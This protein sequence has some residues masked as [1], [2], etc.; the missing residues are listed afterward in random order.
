MK[1]PFVII[2][3]VLLFQTLALKA[4]VADNDGN[5]ALINDYASISKWDRNTSEW[6]PS[7]QQV[8][9]YDEGMNLVQIVSLNPVTSDTLSRVIYVYDDKGSMTAE[10][11]QDYTAGMWVDKLRYIMGYDENDMRMSLTIYVRSNGEWV[12]SSRQVNYRYDERNLLVAYDNELWYETGWRLS[13]VDNFT[14]D[15][16]GIL[17]FRIRTDMT[18]ANAFRIYYYYNAYQ[19][20]TQMFVQSYQR[21]TGLWLN[22]YRDTYFY[23]SCGTRISNLRERFVNGS[24]I[25]E[26]KADLFY[27][28]TVFTSDNKLKIPVCHKGTTIYVRLNQLNIHLGHGDC[29]GECQAGDT[30]DGGKPGRVNGRPETPPFSVFPNPAS[31]RLSVRLNG[32]AGDEIYRLELTD[33]NGRVIRVSSLNGNEEI[34]FYRGTLPAGNYYIKLIGDVVYSTMVVFR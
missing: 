8:Y 5:W 7:L 14:Y 24:W 2:I 10:Y 23:N 3:S 13:F 21:T 28:V 6:F 34:T 30:D 26:Q 16:Q 25:N 33:H 27:K 1:T 11:F 17:V 29:I 4:Q 12:Y 9:V 22:S 31:D 19:Q 15:D 18:G 32:A 20:R